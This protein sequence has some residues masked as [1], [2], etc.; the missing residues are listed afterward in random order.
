LRQLSTLVN[1]IGGDCILTQV[2]NAKIGTLANE[3]G[4]NLVE[5]DYYENNASA[6]QSQAHQY[7]QESGRRNA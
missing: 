3:S 4:I 1:S 6:F 5:G 2:E 7:K